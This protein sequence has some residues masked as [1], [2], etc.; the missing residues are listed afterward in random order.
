MVKLLTYSVAGL[1]VGAAAS[2]IAAWLIGPNIDKAWWIATNAAAGPG[3]TL[4][5]SITGREFI[6]SVI[7][8]GVWVIL[9]ARRIEQLEREARR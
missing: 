8:M 2:F 1:L 7:G 4:T 3:V 5:Q 9:L 6:G